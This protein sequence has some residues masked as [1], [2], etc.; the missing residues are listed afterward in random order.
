MGYILREITPLEKD[1][2]FY[3]KFTPGDPMDFPIHFHADFEVT[4]VK[5]VK[6]KRIVGN[7]VEDIDGLD[8]VL[9]GP[10]TLH[11][12]RWDDHA[13]GDVAVIQFSR[14]SI[15]WQMFS[16][17]VLAPIG[18]MLSK[19]RA[20]I[21]FS[22]K[23]AQELEEKIIRLHEA[24]GLESALLFIEIL[25]SL[26]CAEDYKVLSVSSYKEPSHKSDRINRILN[27]IETN[28]MNKISLTD[29][30]DL[31]AMSPVSVSRYFKHKTKRT[32][33]EY[34]TECR[35]GHAINRML[36]SDEYISDICYSCGFN[37]IT[38]FN[39]VFKRQMG[40][41]PREYRSKLNDV[42]QQ[43]H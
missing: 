35:I 1:K 8:L 5:G 17:D 28:Y 24:S 32:F 42:F 16:K 37:S 40:M 29:I 4:L 7:S 41:S 31:V 9:I 34:L 18:E 20:G 12:Y 11:G 19:T 38:N 39:R 14:Q 26:A 36:K 2:L 21:R 33:G 6:G 13:F 25:Y 27:F 22:Q 43:T 15:T 30:A 3:A 23:T 10:D